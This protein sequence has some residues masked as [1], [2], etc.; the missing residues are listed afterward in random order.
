MTREP[1]LVTLPDGARLIALE[2]HQDPR[3]E[4]TEIFRNEWHDSPLPVHWMVQRVAANALHGMHV[5]PRHWRYV[6]V[7]AGETVIGLHDMKPADAASRR[8]ATLR[9]DCKRLQ[10]LV[11]P[12]GVAHGCYAPS[13]AMLLVA[14]SGCP[15]PSDDHRCR[16]DSPDLRL[17]W[18]CAAPDLSSL[19]RCAASYAEG[20]ASLLAAMAR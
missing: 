4:L 11:I 19:D 16:W 8:S 12:P 2:T 3:G 14:S 17:N 5:H 7:V 18:P 13:D 15:A 6:C 20:R 10:M 9:G 1:P